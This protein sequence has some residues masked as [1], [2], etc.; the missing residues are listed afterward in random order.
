MY[1]HFIVILRAVDSLS[2]RAQRGTSQTTLDENRE[3][4]RFA[5]NDSHKKERRLR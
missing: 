5:Q 3:V 2:S 4:L 1:Y